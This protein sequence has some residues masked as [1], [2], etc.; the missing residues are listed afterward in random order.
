MP[1]NILVIDDHDATRELIESILSRRGYTVRCADSGAQG[2]VLV[3]EETPDLVLLDYNMPVMDGFEVLEKIRK[4]PKSAH[5]PVIMFTAKSEASTKLTG[6]DL[7]ADDFLTKPTSPKELLRRVEIQLNRSREIFSDDQIDSPIEPTKI[8]VP[9]IR[10]DTPIKKIKPSKKVIAVI[11]AKGGVGT[12]VTAINLAVCLAQ[13]GNETSLVD[14]DVTQG[15]VAVYLRFQVKDGLNKLAGLDDVALDIEVQGQFVPGPENLHFLLS[16]S[17]VAGIHPTIEPRQIEPLLES[18]HTNKNHLVFD[19]GRGISPLGQELFKKADHVI[20]CIR[21][22]RLSLSAAKQ[23]L[24]QI[25]STH[26]TLPVAVLLNDFRQRKGLPRESIEQ[27]LGHS[28]FDI[29]KINENQLVQ[30]VN[31][32]QSLVSAHPES[33]IVTQYQKL[34]QLLLQEN[35]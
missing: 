34:G 33:E 25:K 20:L 14:L 12:T 7:G 16:K 1:A 9:P 2:L 3:D 4:K 32:G 6:F 30:A 31:T 26:D 19:L 21:P 29:I 35:A 11:G 13:M 15:H 5:L 10:P 22:D 23:I 28:L 24:R 8:T 17:N 18:I 27:F